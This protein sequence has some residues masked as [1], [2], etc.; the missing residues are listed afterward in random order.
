[1]TFV[2]PIFEWPF[3]TGFTIFKWAAIG[4]NV[5]SDKCG[6]TR[7]RHKCAHQI[8]ANPWSI[9]VSLTVLCEYL[10][11]KIVLIMLDDLCTSSPNFIQITC[12]ISFINL[13]LQEASWPGSTLFSKH[14]ITGFSTECLKLISRRVLYSACVGSHR[15]SQS[16][17][18]PILN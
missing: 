12:R 17:L 16:E 14:N 11:K 6:L 3:K 7:P 15:T 8:Q 2:L 10:T 18:G 4:Q 5:P 9:N 1:M 13:N